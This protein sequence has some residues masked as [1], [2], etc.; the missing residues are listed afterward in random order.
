MCLDASLLNK[1]IACTLYVARQLR[2]VLQRK[3]ATKDCYHSN[4]GTS[5]L[6]C[7][8]DDVARLCQRDSR[9]VV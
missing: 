9:L 6:A 7:I 5:A 3:A 1:Y 8:T 4:V 2:R